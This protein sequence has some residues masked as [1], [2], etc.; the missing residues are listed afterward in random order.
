MSKFSLSVYLNA[1]SDNC[2]SNNPSQNNFKWARDINS[3]IVNNPTNQAN[4][5]APGETRSFFSGLRTLLQDGTTQYSIALAPL[6]T[7]V[8]ALSWVG[9]AAPNFR[10]ARNTGASS[11]TQVTAVVNGPI[12]TF[13]STGGT[14]FNFAGSQVGDYVS[15]GSLFNVLNQGTF[16]II[17]LTSTS[18]TVSIPTGVNEGPITLGSGFATQIQVFSAAGVQVGDTLVISGGFS[19]ATQGSYIVTAVYANSIW[20]SSTSLLPIQGPITTQAITIYSNAKTL[21][22]VESD[23]ALHVIL[24]NVDIGVIQPFV[25]PNAA[26]PSFPPTIVPGV[27]MLKSTI[28]SLSVTNNGINTANVYFAAIE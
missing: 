26:Q 24:N 16:Q 17:G 8:Y 5:V 7:S 12:V 23:Q 11:T 4:T 10:T 14:P 15:I 22:Y 19:L 20:F 18:F 1:Y 3:I 9:G 21:V 28:W 25:S 13:T 27:F 2:P 6:Q